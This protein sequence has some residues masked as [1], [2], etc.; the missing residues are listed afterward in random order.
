VVS[1]DEGHH[2]EYAAKEMRWML[3]QVGCREVRRTLF[4][5]N[6][7]Q[8]HELTGQHIKALLA[9]TADRTLADSIL[10][11]GAVPRDIY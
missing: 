7:F 9:I 6:L 10:A 1:D 3:E 5:Q 8:F 2:R 4:A 11:A